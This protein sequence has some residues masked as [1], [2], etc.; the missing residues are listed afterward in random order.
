[1]GTWQKCVAACQ[2]AISQ[3]KSVVVDNTNADKKT[4][5]RF[6]ILYDSSNLFHLPRT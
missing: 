3:G 6:V 5:Q 1:M 4:R 2:A